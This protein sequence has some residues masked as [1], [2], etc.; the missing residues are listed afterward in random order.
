MEKS[1][2]EKTED[3]KVK[4]EENKKKNRRNVKE[5]NDIIPKLKII[6]GEL[7]HKENIAEIM[8]H[9]ENAPE[10]KKFKD[11]ELNE[12]R[13]K[14]NSLKTKKDALHDESVNLGKKQLE[15]VKLINR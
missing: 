4:L 3:L 10:L 12:L 11:R 9:F 8:N 1:K 13:A 6:E 7:N 5:W 15:L 14:Y 2:T